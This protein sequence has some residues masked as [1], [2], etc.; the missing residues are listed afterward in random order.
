MPTTVWKKQQ[1]KREE[2]SE[3]REVSGDVRER[4]DG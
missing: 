4:K 2:R 1:N 3:E